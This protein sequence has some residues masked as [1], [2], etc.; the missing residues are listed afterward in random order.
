MKKLPPNSNFKFHTS[1]H[2]SSQEADDKTGD[3]TFTLK[4]QTFTNKEFLKWFK[5]TVERICDLFNSYSSNVGGAFKSDFFFAL[6][7][8]GGKPTEDRS[9]DSI[10]KK[11]SVIKI[12]NDDNSCFWHA[13]AV[14]KNINH[15]NYKSIRQGRGIRT[16]LA[17]ALCAR[18]DMKW[19][20]QVSVD[21]FPDIERQVKCN[22]YFLNANELPV[23]NTTV[24]FFQS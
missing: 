15:E 3:T 6:T 12:N 24:T 14:L 4:S 20:E 23:L 9:L 18:C 13:L 1:I 5:L 16:E 7:P 17:K 21:A 22:V 19:D 11:K 8:T 10:Y 2:F